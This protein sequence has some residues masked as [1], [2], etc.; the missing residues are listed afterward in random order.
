MTEHSVRSIPVRFQ[1]WGSTKP[2]AI[3]FAERS[4]DGWQTTSWAEYTELVRTVGRALIA[5]GVSPGDRVAIVG[6]NAARWVI[7][8]M[9]V[10]S[11][12]AVSVGIYPA[13]SAEQMGGIRRHANAD[14]VFV[15]S[16][17][18][19]QK[20]IDHPDPPRILVRMAHGNQVAPGDQVTPG[21]HDE[22]GSSQRRSAIDWNEF[23]SHASSISTSE[24]DERLASIRP[25]APAMLV[26]TSGTTGEPR[27][28]V[29]T[30]AGLEACTTAG[31]QMISYRPDD[32]RVLSY[33]PLAHIAERGVSVLGPAYLGYA[34]YF[35]RSIEALPR[36][37]LEVR[38]SLFLGVPRVYEKIQE[39][40]EPRLDAAR[41]VGGF[42]MRWARR[43]A[44]R[45]VA[46]RMTGAEPSGRLERSYQRADRLVLSRIARALGLDRSK[47]FLS[48]AAP[49]SVQTLAF[50]ASIGML[51]Q[52]VYGLS[53]SGGVA[54]FNRSDA[55]RF[56][57]VGRPFDG[58]QIEV[59]DDGEIA[60]AGPNLFAGYL[61]DPEATG[62]AL[63]E[64]WLLTGDLGEF[65]EDGFLYVT[66]RKKDILVTAG[67]KNIV[68]RPIEK[69]IAE[70]PLVSD[71]LV[72]GDRRK[73]LVAL[74]LLDEATSA[75]DGG[76]LDVHADI[77]QHIDEMNRSL[78]NP[79]TIKRFA[80][81]PRA[82]DQARGELTPTMKVVRGVVKQ[83]FASLIDS[84]YE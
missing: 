30:H 57:S 84:L 17:E 23:V 48:G 76:D 54:S 7:V 44:S 1:E 29:L 74:V 47:V 35:A 49:M 10:M 83:N 5:L 72:V 28:V 27:G 59:R 4:E 40:L 22:A 56:G 34:V 13:S 58:V 24:F 82:L 12:G 15:D 45:F 20:L 80:I 3:A 73:Y 43:V 66:G 53:E 21:D 16:D 75:V 41:G 81:L 60:V 42:L 31:V 9:A 64:G 52:E 62:A 65:D 46:L 33:L 77:Q 8:D 79:E 78:S 71:A 18:Q 50:F 39:K 14:V 51:V 69:R 55:A 6:A 38:P 26:Y 37:L 70:H 2:Q 61:D 67:G 63:N 32:L 36:D 25:D 19:Q 11:I 68:P